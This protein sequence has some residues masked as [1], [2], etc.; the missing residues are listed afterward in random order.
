MD[1][2]TP[3][4]AATIEGELG[5]ALRH[6]EDGTNKHQSTTEARG[7]SYDDGSNLRIP[8]AKK[9]P[10]VQITKFLTFEEPIQVT[11]SDSIIRVNASITNQASQQYAK[12]KK[13]KLT[14][15]T[16]GG[17]IQLHDFEIV[18]THL[19]P[20]DK[21]LTLYVKDFKSLGSNG[22]GNFGSAPQAIERRERPMELLN[23]LADLR[24]HGWD[25]HSEQSATASPTRSQPSTQTSEVGKSQDSQIGFATQVPRS[26]APIVSKAT[27][28]DP[29]TGI[30]IR[31]NSHAKS[32][33]SLAPPTTGG[34]T[35]HLAGT[36]SSFPTAPQRPNT[37]EGLLG[38]LQQQKNRFAPPAPEVVSEPTTEKP[39]GLTGDSGGRAVIQSVSEASR[40]ITLA[41][42][43]H[44][45]HGAPFGAAK[46]KR[47]SPENSP[48]KKAADEIDF[49]RIDIDRES[50]AI[51]QDPDSKARSGAAM[52]EASINTLHN[53]PG[54][55]SISES[56]RLQPDTPPEPLIDATSK[57]TSSASGH[58]TGRNRISSRDVKIPKDQ[59]V[60]L[61][62][63]DS[64]LPAEPGQREPT[65][66]IPITLLETLN[67]KANLRAQRP[68]HI[69][70]QRNSEMTPTGAIDQTADSESDVPVSSGQWPASPERDQLPPDSSSASAEHSDHSVQR[71][72]SKPHSVSSS[73]RQSQASNSSRS[74]PSR[75]PSPIT[76]RRFS[77]ELESLSMASPGLL[78]PS[79]ASTSAGDD[80][81]RFVCQAPGCD[82]SYKNPNGL[83][84]HVDRHH[85]S[86]G[87]FE[88]FK[89]PVEDCIKSY[90]SPGGLKYH[91]E[92]Y[93]DGSTAPPSR[94]GSV[95][96]IIPVASIP[97]FPG[98]ESW[99]KR[100][101][102]A[103]SK[104]IDGGADNE[105]DS[106]EV[107]ASIF[108]LFDRGSR[109]PKN[110]DFVRRFSSTSSVLKS[111]L[112]P[113]AQPALVLS[114]TKNTDGTHV[115]KET[116]PPLLPASP[117]P[118]SDLEM[119]VPLALNEKTDSIASSAPVQR[120][121]ST[122]S[123]PQDPFTQVKR[124]PYVNGRVQN[125]SL[126]GFRSLS[127]PLKANSN[128]LTNGT[129]N[130]DTESVS[131]SVTSG[132]ETS[133]AEAHDETVSFN[134]VED[135][136]TE[137][138]TATL[139]EESNVQNV[140]E[141]ILGK[142][143]NLILEV[144][145][146]SGNAATV[147]SIPD[148]SS[149]IT[150]KSQYQISESNQPSAPGNANAKTQS[151]AER[152]PTPEGNPTDHLPRLPTS[153]HAAQVAHEI[154]R[155]V[156][157]SSFVSPSLAKRQKRFK[158]PSA[159]TFTERSEV[160]RDPSEGARQYRQDFL[161]SRRSSESST[162]TMSPTMPFTNFPG[163][164]S[165]NPRDPRE[166]ARQIRQEFLASR[167]SSAT[168][169]PATSPRVQSAALTGAIQAGQRNEMEMNV[170]KV[171]LQNQ[172]V[173]TEIEH[174]KMT[175]L[176]ELSARS[177]MQEI[178]V[179]SAPSP[180]STASAT[181]GDYNAEPG[182]QDTALLDYEA[183][184]RKFVGQ[185]ADAEGPDA[186]EANSSAS[187]D[188]AQRAQSVDLDVSFHLS[189]HQEAENEIANAN[190]NANQS[191]EPEIDL[192]IVSHDQLANNNDDSRPVEPEVAEPRK[193]ISTRID[194]VAE[195]RRNA[196]TPDPV[197]LNQVTE[198]SAAALGTIHQRLIEGNTEFQ[199][200]D[201][202]ASEP[203]FQ[204]QPVTVEADTLLSEGIATEPT[205][206]QQW[207]GVD[208]ANSIQVDQD[209]TPLIPIAHTGEPTDKRTP[210]S[211]AV[212]AF[213][214]ES[215]A[216][217]QLHLSPAAAEHNP[218]FSGHTSDSE[219]KPAEEHQNS[220]QLPV[221]TVK[222]KSPV[223]P[224]N[225][226]DK[227]K[228]AY[229]AYPGDM[230]HFAAICRK[231]SQLFQANRM[232]HQSLWDDFI[233]RHKLEYSQ[234]LRRCAE[235][236][237][238]AVPY[239]DFYQ[240]EI[241]APQ[242][243][244]RIISRRNLDEALALVAQKPSV[245]QV[246]VEFLKEDEPYVKPVEHK[247]TSGPDPVLE[248]MHH[249][250]APARNYEPRKPMATK[251]APKPASSNKNIQKPSKSQVAVDVSAQKAHSEA[252]MDD[253]PPVSS[254]N[255]EYTLK[256]AN[257]TG[258]AQKPTQSRVTIDLTG[259]DQP[260]D[261]PKRTKEKGISPQSGV[262]HLSNGV[263]GEPPSLQ[264]R[265]DRSG[266]P[267]QV[268]SSRVPPP[269][270]LIRSPL[271]TA[272][273]STR[274]TTKSV[275]RSLPWNKPNSFV[276]QSSAVATASDSPKSP[277]ASDLREI[278]AEESDNAH[279]QLLTKSAPN[280]AK[281][282]QGLLNT[283]HRVIQSNWG[284]EA[285]ELLEPEYC[286]GQV[287]SETMIELLA[288]IASKV[289]VG[290]AR[291]RIKAA[292]D[293]RIKDNARRG[294]GH[295]S[296][297]RKMLKADLEVV[298]G[299]VETSSMSTASPFS[300][301]HTNAA[302]EK[303]DEDT[304]SK[305]WDDDH[306]PFK[307]FAR[308]YASIRHGNGNSFAKADSAEAGDA[309]KVHEAARSG[310]QLKKINI[311]GWNL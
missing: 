114:A 24:K 281:Q 201:K 231:I 103:G 101:G 121:P 159:F 164:M 18:A 171:I 190:D 7:L 252:V 209:I 66:N 115:A 150:T 305:W 28:R 283:C 108:P 117:T 293:T 288:E 304:P 152:L 112:P 63:T 228:E 87:P 178:Q 206:Q 109:T 298:R 259:D 292:I 124:T 39:P 151:T 257:P 211:F 77:R 241:E 299:V 210:L 291:N 225:I 163:T 168:S 133:S 33:K 227:F 72:S 106:V 95:T 127:S 23:K 142:P 125:H 276:P 198:P 302:V 238:D 54:N 149:L 284:L 273:A 143:D 89:C 179:G 83:K 297:D 192:M 208:T 184:S 1:A 160:P 14:E 303:H 98:L 240:T 40:D 285:H 300:L 266:S 73:R 286:R 16:V 80:V 75:R 278:G 213:V 37:R 50:S 282:G 78:S 156:A 126:S 60:L 64:W 272:T 263:S 174:Q 275:R 11:L 268:R 45:A 85:P 19:G 270:E 199:V 110:R 269:P 309:E 196:P 255:A 204:Q 232:E 248:K 94:T 35:N 233:V 162:P 220:V 234:Y 295:P 170:E 84:Y 223:E 74:M 200:P 68:N 120:F 141:S 172:S 265:R 244:K 100:N 294:A 155:K 205:P 249:K 12:Q 138:V 82:K 91:I 193:D 214:A 148:D 154:K 118:E 86:T 51:D 235:E 132:P 279:I 246:H 207:V 175:E 34:H 203:T 185:N 8:S 135:R 290:E 251:S 36:L 237:E 183:Q 173:D 111:S 212:P 90:A 49:H 242:Y 107:S 48:R 261:Q 166:R 296:Q 31:S 165:E 43:D 41:P 195:Q 81:Q 308:A 27:P 53:P 46:R 131:A 116:F 147:A 20:R 5:E 65:A 218:S 129:I 22:S 52:T 189:N 104:V 25:A 306:S 136:G 274:S 30:N 161:A 262:P 99:G 113:D 123:Q 76:A 139:P 307:S 44:N 187:N 96:P 221:E 271:V 102:D 105:S 264:Y 130:D 70:K 32:V 177:Q 55:P 38:L 15:G 224:Q 144:K 236:A 169:T 140:T 186:V 59:E 182:A 167:R 180:N 254:F 215:H 13:K 56:P 247:S 71:I 219:M 222:Q 310:V 58:N 119:T 93:H 216:E 197:M 122:A 21:R 153:N 243:H 289:N 226:F 42:H 230:K 69:R 258:I 158:I 256:K 134:A 17:L 277:L 191:V 287:L 62:R 245:K 260:D 10:V 253:E 79:F 311:M 57:L 4:L 301:P 239:E 2:L 47:R 92:R 217:N 9:G 202:T 29:T 267:Y 128:P 229:P 146:G 250:Y 88:N 137:I 181:A 157:D 61:S 188:E 194:K 3:W 6:R 26:Q 67:R 176:K 145:Q 280:C 97:M